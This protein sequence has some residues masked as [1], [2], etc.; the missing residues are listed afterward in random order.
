MEKL[1]SK[2]K[3]FG[4]P[5]F[6]AKKDSPLT[7]PDGCHYRIE[8]SGVEDVKTLQALVDEK[9]KRGVPVH[10]IVAAV[11]GT[12]LLDQGELREFAQ[13]AREE[14]LE[15]VIVAGHSRGWDTG[16]TLATSEGALCGVRVRGADGI[17]NVLR[18]MQRCIDAGFRGFLVV[19]E[20]MLWLVT[21][22][23][24]KGYIPKDTK[25]KV[26]VFAGHASPAGARLLESMGADTF[27]PLADVSIEMM[28]SIRQVCKI[29]IDVYAYVVDT[30]G[31]MCRFFDAAEIARVAA[32][33]YFKIEPGVS[34]YGIYKPW[35]SDDFH[36][37]FIRKKVKYAEIIQEMVA[38]RNSKMK[39][40]PDAP[41]DLVLTQP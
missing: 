17:A 29:P 26:S 39:M 38:K 37:S 23:R 28:S 40:S 24:D 9:K 36:P 19:D 27:N 35:V 32:P 10:R 31:G 30:M 22:M 33:V 21:Q 4:I 11:G 34:E 41:A 15:V 7:F 14:K 25:F 13:I 18:D 1:V 12:G 8:I 6:D 2:M 5:T 16:R 20:G 3:E